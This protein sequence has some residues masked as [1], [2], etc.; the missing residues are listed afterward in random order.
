[1]YR[2]HI[3]MKVLLTF[4]AL[5]LTNTV[6]CQWYAQQPLSDYAN[7]ESLSVCPRECFCPPDFPNTLYCNNRKLKEVPVIP[8]RIWYLHLQENVIET[9]SEK[10]F[11]NPIELKWINLSKNKL[12]SK[13][14]EK[15]VFRK[16]KNLLY[17]YLNDNQLE[18]IP[19]P[20]PSSLEQLHLARNKISRIPDGAF[21]SLGNLTLLDLHHNILKNDVVM[22]NTFKGLKNLLQLNLAKNALKKMPPT[23][24]PT[25]LQLFLDNNSIEAIPESYFNAVPKLAFLRLNHNKLSDSGIP[26]NVFNVSS[27][28]D[29]QLSYNELTLI[30]TIHASLE[31]L[32]LNDNK[33]KSINGTV[34]CP[35]SIAT[36]QESES[37]YETGPRL[38]YL[39]LD[40][41]QIQLPLPQDLLMCFRLLHAVVI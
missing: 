18:E 12:S 37:F 21:S 8:S 4:V 39:R 3:N 26:K 23:L 35:T 1:F 27:I 34:M 20:L 33:I 5:F 31:H 32:H 14:I 13:G 11:P 2:I 15:G 24:P 22:D 30:P 17:L 7:P 6:W 36:V 16:I 40:G 38:R 41:N 9:I 25:T 29:L 10:S 28:L 19:A